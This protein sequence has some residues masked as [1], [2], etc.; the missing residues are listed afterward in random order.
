MVISPGHLVMSSDGRDEEPSGRLWAGIDVGG[1]RKGFH[2]A[3]VDAQRLVEG[4]VP[5]A[6]PDDAAE[7]VAAHGACLTAVDSPRRAAPAGQRSRPCERGF[8]VCRLR[9]T[10]DREA[11][12]AHPT[13]YEWVLHGF[14]LYRAL[15]RRGLD[16]IECF[17]TASWTVWG[18]PRQHRSRAAWSEATLRGLGLAG[19]PAR[20]NQDER[21]AI[22]AALTAR[23]YD[24]A[25]GCALDDIVIPQPWPARGHGAR[26]ERV[27]QALRSDSGA[28]E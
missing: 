5:I 9:Y 10:P 3:L 22:G 24:P 27:A 20:L 15:A 12:V 8:S 6:T 19:V 18:K 2:L 26:C 25:C 23:S 7:W 17:P 4:P 14:A 11:L 28:A 13:Y 21:D 1:R 16:V